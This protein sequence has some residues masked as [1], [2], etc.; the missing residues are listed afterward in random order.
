MGLLP[1]GDENPRRW[2]GHPYFTWGIVGFCVGVFL[3]Q[4][5]QGEDGFTRALY[6]YGVIPTVLLGPHTLDPQIERVPAWA[7]L[8]T[9]Q[10]LHGS[11][12]H[13]GGN[14]LFL[15]VFGDNIE[16]S[17]GHG[18]FLVFYLLCGALAGLGF[19]LSDP[20]GEAPTIGASGAVAGVLGGYIVLHPKVR[21][22]VLIGIWLIRIPAFLVL[23]IWIGL[24]ILNAL[25]MKAGESEVAFWAHVVGFFAGAILVCFFKRRAV[26][27]LSRSQ[28]PTLRI[29]GLP[30]RNPGERGPWGQA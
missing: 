22:L 18:R 27:L 1:L 6:G 14:M 29:V 11:W 4:V 26:P 5:T 13:L 25:Y 24:E 16:D 12:L 23:G 15:W 19:A 20:S 3:W 2:I 7:T 17:M 8:I 28:E 9:S 30:R 10:F 21:I